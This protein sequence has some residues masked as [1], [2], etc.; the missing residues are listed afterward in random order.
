MK[1]FLDTSF[2]VSCIIETEHS[3]KVKKILER[4][5][6]CALYTSINAV[7]ETVYV[8]R[9][10]AKMENKEISERVKSVIEK[11][12][13][14]VITDLP[15]STFFEILENYSLLSNDALI[16]ATC[17]YYGISKIATFDEDF[18]KVDFLEVVKV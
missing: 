16:A 7:E 3:E 6:N 10:I 8:I 1:V 12:S 11:L 5:I 13:I 18:E 14:V 17:K 15:L 9:K 4:V 2:L